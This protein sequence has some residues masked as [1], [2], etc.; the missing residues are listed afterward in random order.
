MILLIMK[1]NCLA[2]VNRLKPQRLE[3]VVR[4]IEEDGSELV[5][6]HSQ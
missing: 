2:K 5:L 1:F 3:E 4:W 6:G